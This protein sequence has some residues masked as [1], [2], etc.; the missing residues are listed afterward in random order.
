MIIYFINLCDLIDSIL[1]KKIELFRLL[2]WLAEWNT[3]PEN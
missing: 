2:R 1:K 3:A